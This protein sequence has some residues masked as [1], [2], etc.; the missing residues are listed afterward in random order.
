M[1]I[2]ELVILVLFQIVILGSAF[3]VFFLFLPDVVKHIKNSD[4]I[5]YI[6]IGCLIGYLFF[7]VRI[8]AWLEPKIQAT[9][10][11]ICTVL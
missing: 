3:S 2:Y 7:C 9:T 10:T 1:N 6:Y 11:A 5:A 8:L 4:A